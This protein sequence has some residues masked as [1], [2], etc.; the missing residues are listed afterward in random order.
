MV[1]VILLNNI[2]LNL[3][4]MCAWIISSSV[5]YNNKT[6]MCVNILSAV[7]S[8]RHMCVP[9]QLRWCITTRRTHAWTFSNVLSAVMH[10]NNQHPHNN[11]RHACLNNYCSDVQHCT[12]TLASFRTSADIAVKWAPLNFL[13]NISQTLSIKILVMNLWRIK[14]KETISRKAIS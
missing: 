11:K 12:W 14:I 5:M 6:H 3:T 1:A 2:K 9:D 7:M 10:N 13:K 4:H 8:T